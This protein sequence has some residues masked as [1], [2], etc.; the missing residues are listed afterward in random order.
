MYEEEY[1]WAQLQRNTSNCKRQPNSSCS[2]FHGLLHVL[3]R[4]PM[5]HYGMNLGRVGNDLGGNCM[6]LIAQGCVTHFWPIFHTI[7]FQIF[8]IWIGLHFQVQNHARFGHHSVRTSQLYLCW[9]GLTVIFNRSSIPYANRI[10]H[11]S[12][13]YA[14]L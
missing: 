9:Q 14:R 4:Q 12:S 2:C 13:I 8:R 3:V 7:Q 1:S 5:W 11:L 6:G 10:T